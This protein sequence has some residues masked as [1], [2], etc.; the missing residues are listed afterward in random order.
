MTR[1]ARQEPIELVRSLGRWSLTGLVL[2][3]VIG[4]SVFVLPGPLA[5]RLGV[6]SLAAWAIAAACCATMILCFAEVASR[7]SGTGGAYLFTRVA[8]GPFVGLQVGWLSYF[9]RAITAAVQANVF[10]TYLAGFWPWAGT[11][12]GGIAA[13][14][15]FIGFLAAVNIR[16][17][18]SGAR[19]SN[20][21]ALV[22]IT[23]LLLFGI[24]GL[25]WIAGGK[26]VPA[27]VPSDPSLAGWLEVLLLL[28]FAYGGF[29]S[30]VIPLAE[31]KHPRRDAPVALLGGLALA[32]LLYLL[33]QLTVLASLPD[34]G[35]T[36]RPLAESG[37]VLL[38]DTGAAII[39]L[40]ALISV[41]GWLASNMLAVPRL[42]MAMAERGDFPE[43][44]AR[45]HPVFR[46]PWLSIL[47][48]AA[49][50]WVLANQAG[51]L[52]NL[53]LASVSRLFVYGLVCA[54]LPVLRRR[55]GGD[56]PPPLFQAPMGVGLAI[57]GIAFSLA[58]ATRINL[59]EAVTL[60]LTVTTATGYWLI[61]RRKRG[62]GRR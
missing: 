54:A 59:R 39:T 1:S 30:A 55:E 58:L 51:L 32:A 15:L 62:S 13:T 53:S 28:V 44:F 20:G 41:Y 2:N 47:F 26:G 24:M 43:F 14:T 37:R 27:P 60:G 11:R 10:S 34:P 40:T 3:G 61:S 9:V 56:I 46:T 16:S 5:D 17:V 23:P 12:L 6:M 29:E 7:F 35:A 21:F 22:K 49:V 25:V 45:V 50:S 31:A 36:S 57:I 8:F 38:G 18:I 4:S 33:A 42:S 19:V 48:F 52:E